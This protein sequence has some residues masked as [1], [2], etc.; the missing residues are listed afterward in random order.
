MQSSCMW[1]VGRP[2]IRAKLIGLSAAL[3]LS[4][5]SNA[6]ADDDEVRSDHRPTAWLFRATPGFGYSWDRDVMCAVEGRMMFGSWFVGKFVTP[7]LVVG[8]ALRMDANALPDDGCVTNDDGLRMTI[9]LIL[10]PEI[11]WYPFDSGLHVFAGGG[12]ATF[13]HDSMYSAYGVGGT[14][15]VGYDWAFRKEGAR[16][17]VR[18]G[19]AVQA[20]TVRMTHGHDM[21]MTA[22]VM[23]VGAEWH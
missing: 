1:W 10:G 19:L 11:G 12:F 8:G 3:L 20:S 17:G 21:T 13:D 7:S 4:A 9:G 2:G 5:V 6:V 14:V 15:A 16:D 22:G 23:T 18:F